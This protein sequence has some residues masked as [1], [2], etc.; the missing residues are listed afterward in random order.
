MF[1]CWKFCFVRVIQKVYSVPVDVI[2]YRTAWREPEMGSVKLNYRK[3]NIT[4]G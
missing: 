4:C 1:Y 3:L 2:M